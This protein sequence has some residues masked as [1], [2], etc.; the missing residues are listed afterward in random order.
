MGYGLRIIDGK[1]DVFEVGHI[2]M[3]GLKGL[4]WGMQALRVLVD[5]QY[6]LIYYAVRKDSCRN[7]KRKT[8]LILDDLMQN[9]TLS[10]CLDDRLQAIRLVL[11]RFVGGWHRL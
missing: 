8:S 4:L 10:W 1:A 3:V 7:V 5:S 2:G 6:L 11:I 9:E